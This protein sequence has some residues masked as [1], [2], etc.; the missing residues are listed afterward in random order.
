MFRT[1]RHAGTMTVTVCTEARC[2]RSR[3]TKK[4]KTISLDR[5]GTTGDSVVGNGVREWNNN[6]QKKRSF[7]TRLADRRSS[8]PSNDET[9]IVVVA[10]LW[11]IDR[12]SWRSYERILR[13]ARQTDVG[14]QTFWTLE[15]FPI[16]K[17]LRHRSFAFSTAA[18]QRRVAFFR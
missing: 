9:K 16:I 10:W 2:L 11:L 18:G 13:S 12:E 5:G 6:E 14:H 15:P 8:R 1:I 17:S 4:R 7:K 3:S